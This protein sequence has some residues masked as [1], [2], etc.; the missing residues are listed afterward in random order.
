MIIF[1]A[2]LWVLFAN[3]CCFDSVFFVVKSRAFLATLDFKLSGTKTER[4]PR[5]AWERLAD[6]CFEFGCLELIHYSVAENLAVECVKAWCSRHTAEI[7]C[8]INLPVLPCLVY[9]IILW[10]SG[11]PV[12][13]P[14]PDFGFQGWAYQ[15]SLLKIKPSQHFCLFWCFVGKFIWKKY[16]KN[17]I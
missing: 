14:A 15:L 7:M 11:I 4:T 5:D 2:V 12:S 13:D 9:C 6:D 8:T 17:I 1:L 3:V 16:F 10:L